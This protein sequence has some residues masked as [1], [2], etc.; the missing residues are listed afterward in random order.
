MR[1][2]QNEDRSAGRMAPAPSEGRVALRS[3]TAR[4][5]CYGFGERQD[6]CPNEP[7]GKW[8]ADCEEMDRL[9]AALRRK[10]TLTDEEREDLIA[11]LEAR[12]DSNAEASGEGW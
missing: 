3:G 6:N 2:R 4:K 12:K 10:G 11:V 8:C 5:F 9:I 7:G 1:D